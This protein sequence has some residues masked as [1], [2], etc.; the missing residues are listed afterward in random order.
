MSVWV[1]DLII[2][3][4]LG[5]DLAIGAHFTPLLCALRCSEAVRSRQQ[6]QSAYADWTDQVATEVQEVPPIP[7]TAMVYYSVGQGDKDVQIE[8]SRMRAVAN[9]G[10]ENLVVWWVVRGRDALRCRSCGWWRGDRTQQGAKCD[11]A[12]K[13][14]STKQGQK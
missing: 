6:S 3:A 7:Y 11:I 9:G 1:A 5:S 14:S 2:R 8:A 12:D 13:K 10:M 4:R